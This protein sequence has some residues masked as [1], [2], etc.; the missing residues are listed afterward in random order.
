MNQSLFRAALSCIA[1]LVVS[2]LMADNN[3]ESKEPPLEY[4]VKVGGKEFSV[5]EGESLKLDGEFKNP[6][7]NITP[8]PYREF[9]CQGVKFK[10]PQQFTF[11]SSVDSPFSKSWTLSGNDL[12]IM[13]FAMQGDLSSKD[14]ANTMIQQFGRN[15]AKISDTTTRMKLGNQ[16]LNG[17]T[18]KVTIASHN[19]SMDIMQIPAND[20]ETKL[21]VFQDNVD[22]AGNKSNEGKQTMEVIKS[23]FNLD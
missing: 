14:F 21:I 12:K 10:Y 20:G 13:F 22:A 18:L 2:P 9:D 7:I 15:N 6:V 8:K 23:S 16:T 1:I 5:K 3:D 17:A 4:L 19:M 11:E